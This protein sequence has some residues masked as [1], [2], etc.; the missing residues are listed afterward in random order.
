[1][2]ITTHISSI[3][4]LIPTSRKCHIYLE[5]NAGEKR[6]TR[7]PKYYCALQ[8]W[9]AAAKVTAAASTAVYFPPSS[10]LGARVN[11]NGS[12]GRSTLGSH[13]YT[14]LCRE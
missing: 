6:S 9:A 8:W 7:C 10:T 11:I 3:I 5:S 12:W 4:I 14:A 13:C 1:M 2:K